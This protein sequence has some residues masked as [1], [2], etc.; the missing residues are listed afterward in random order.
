MSLERYR[1]PR[2]VVQ[3]PRTS[4]HDAAR[5]MQSNQVGMVVVQDHRKTVGI[6]T[7]RDLAL[8]V[9]G[10]ELDPRITTLGEIMT[11]PVATLPIDADEQ[12]ALRTMRERHVRRIP[13]VE[14]EHVV[15]VV[16]LDDLIVA[17]TASPAD[18]AM[19]V[20]AQVGAGGPASSRRFDEVRAAQR[21]VARAEE[22]YGKLVHR[23]Q[24]LGNLGSRELAG[25][26]LDVVLT[27]V[28]RRL[29]PHEAAGFVAQLPSMLHDR[30]L[31]LPAGPDR[32]IT[33]ESIETE[34]A[35]RLDLDAP[36]VALVLDVVGAALEHT[37]STGGVANVRNQLPRDMRS[38]FPAAPPA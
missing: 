13:L 26:A 9:I 11:E 38:I 2:V 22:T 36:R 35:K 20:R 32:S 18:L 16:T 21:R 17:G 19:I 12:D 33:R 28:V 34:L 4:V 6:V 14:G 7:D 24:A 30:L 3:T 10:F 23:I 31:D 1:R 29:P 27:G 5:A 15:G 8:R 25:L 37:V